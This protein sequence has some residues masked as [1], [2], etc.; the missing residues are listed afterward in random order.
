MTRPR[1]SHAAWGVAA[2]V[3]ALAMPLGALGGSRVPLKGEDAGAFGPGDHS[4]APG[5]GSLD[6]DGT[7]NATHV[8]KYAYHADECFSPTTLLFDGSFTIIAANGDSIVGTYSGNV[9]SIDFPVAVYEQ[10]AE[11]T[12]GT[13]RFAAATGEFHVSGLANLATGRYSQELSGV[14]SSPGASKR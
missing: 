1:L 10:D 8:G 13:G 2:V 5:Y 14:V 12:G 9:P 6:I 4:C 3:A 11:I 7:G